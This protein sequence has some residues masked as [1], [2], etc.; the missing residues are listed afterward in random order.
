MLT[1]SLCQKGNDIA[2]DEDLCEP[3]DSHERVGFSSNEADDASEFH[4][5]ASSE[6]RRCDQHHDLTDGIWS[7]GVVWLLLGRPNS[8]LM[9][10]LVG[11]CS[12]CQTVRR[13]GGRGAA[14]C[15]IPDTL[16]NTT[17]PEGNEVPSSGSQELVAMECGQED[18]NDTNDGCET[19]VW[20][21]LPWVLAVRHLCG[22]VCVEECLVFVGLLCVLRVWNSKV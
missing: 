7:R 6:E 22:C 12:P 14:Y 9:R 17:Y 21:I 20:L 5:H 1:S 18:E 4:V 8:L 13:G 19:N 16:E 3:G 2:N 10:V 11:C 15:K